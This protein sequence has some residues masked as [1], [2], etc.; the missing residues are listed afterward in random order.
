MIK[1]GSIENS[2]VSYSDDKN[3]GLNIYISVSTRKY[4]REKLSTP[5]NDYSGMRNKD[6]NEM[7]A[8]D[9]ANNSTKIKDLSGI[10][11]PDGGE[12]ISGVVRKS[13]LHNIA[14]IASIKPGELRILTI[15][16]P[17]S[18]KTGTSQT[19]ISGDTTDPV[20]GRSIYVTVSARNGFAKIFRKA[21]PD[22]P[23]HPEA[24]A[25]Y[26]A[27]EF[28]KSAGGVR[29]K[30][31]ITDKEIQSGKSKTKYP[32]MTS[33]GI[34]YAEIRS[35]SGSTTFFVSL[36]KS[37]GSITIVTIQDMWYSPKLQVY[38]KDKKIDKLKNMNVLRKR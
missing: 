21:R 27:K 10:K 9:F 8:N 18:I 6:L 32:S 15:K 24:M 17:G 4:F 20:S 1:I 14:Y 25:K 11:N 31:V 7:I 35:V 2:G 3:S 13:S 29:K 28:A 38:L 16:D 30:W 37:D 33:R 26:I 34:D 12:P 22:M 5:D 19:L 23:F 36:A